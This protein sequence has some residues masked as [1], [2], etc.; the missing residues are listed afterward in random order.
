M[1]ARHVRLGMSMDGVNLSSQQHSN[2]SIG[3]IVLVN[4]KLPLDLTTKVEHI[5][6]SSIVP[7]MIFNIY[8]LMK[9][10]K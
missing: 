1:N 3:P 2:H 5:S 10:Y 6:L 9:V 7:C 8:F 4:P